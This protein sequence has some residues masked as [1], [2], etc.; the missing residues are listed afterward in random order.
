MAHATVAEH[1]FTVGIVIARH[2][3][4]N[5]VKVFGHAIGLYKQYV[6]I[7][8]RLYANGE[9]IF[10][11]GIAIHVFLELHNLEARIMLGTHF[12]DILC[13]VLRD[14]IDNHQLVC[15]IILLEQA[16][17]VFAKPHAVVMHRKHHRHRGIFRVHRVVVVGDTAF[18]TTNTHIHKSVVAGKGD[19]TQRHDEEQDQGKP[20]GHYL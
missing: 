14:E 7:L 6:V 12:Q 3:A 4:A 19:K 20:I 5:P 13:V 2:R 1:Y 8:G 16:R 15:R 17:Q 11:A 10:A 9:R 18:S